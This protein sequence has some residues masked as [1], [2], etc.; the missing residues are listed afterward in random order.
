MK[1]FLMKIFKFMPIAWLLFLPAD[2]IE[3]FRMDIS[4]FVF[5]ILALIFALYAG[6]SAFWL[7]LVGMHH[8]WNFGFHWAVINIIVA[9]IGLLFCF[10]M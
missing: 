6:V 10:S 1:R 2:L 9:T 4:Y 5:A 8:P 3:C 7:L